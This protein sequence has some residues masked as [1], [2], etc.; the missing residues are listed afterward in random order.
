MA[1]HI[2]RKIAGVAL[3]ASLIAAGC[4]NGDAK[5]S[6]APNTPSSSPIGMLETPRPSMAAGSPVSPDASAPVVIEG[7]GNTVVTVGEQSGTLVN[8]FGG[9]ADQWWPNQ[10]PDGSFVPSSW[11]LVDR[12]TSDT[13]LPGVDFKLPKGVVADLWVDNGGQKEAMKAEGADGAIINGDFKVAR[14]T[15][16]LKAAD[17]K[18]SL[19]GK[20]AD[21][22]GAKGM[23][24]DWVAIG[25][26]PTPSPEGASAGQKAY[27]GGTASNSG[28]DVN[29]AP[30]GAWYNSLEQ[31]FG[32]RLKLLTDGSNGVVIANGS[33]VKVT[34]TAGE[35]MDTPN[36]RITKPGTYTVKV[37]T[38]YPHQ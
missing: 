25:T 23:R 10:L 34:L 4:S 1:N 14:A 22:D 3:A 15:V 24:S 13:E 26:L 21:S 17:W 37:A 20:W 29:P 35:V 2:E 7:L 33:A 27:D 31:Q 38:I 19:A 5:T 18:E 8:L 28:P 32:G 6:V 9:K 12:R 30:S 11:V 36:G 16:Y